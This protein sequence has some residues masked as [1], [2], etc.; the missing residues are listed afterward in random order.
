[1]GASSSAPPSADSDP[2]GGCVPH[3]CKGQRRTH[4][5]VEVQPPSSAGALQ[6]SLE[7]TI[8]QK[9]A[10]VVAGGMLSNGMNS[11]AQVFLDVEVG[12]IDAGKDAFAEEPTSGDKQG[13]DDDAWG[14]KTQQDHVANGGSLEKAEDFAEK[15]LVVVRSF[16]H[17][18]HCTVT[19][20]C[21]VIAAG[22]VASSVIGIGGGFGANFKP[23]QYVHAIY[24]IFFAGLIVLLDGEKS[25]FGRLGKYQLLLFHWLPCL[26]TMRGRALLHVYVGS[27]NLAMMSNASNFFWWVVYLSLGGCLCFAGVLL[28]AHH[29]ASACCR[30]RKQRAVERAHAMAKEA[31]GASKEI[32]NQ[33]HGA[34]AW[35]QAEVLEIRVFVRSNHFTVKLF[36]FFIAL[37]LMFFSIL[38]FFNLFHALF[39]PFQYLLGVYNIMF[40]F[41]MLILDGQASWCEKCGDPRKK[42]FRAAPIL[43]SEVGR[44][45][46]HFYVGSINIVMMP[47]S[48]FWQIVYGSL[49]GSLCLASFLM[50]SHYNWCAKTPLDLISAE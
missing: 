48:I 3:C 47:D 5:F 33:V 10:G 44:A 35:G 30:R 24:N 45:A 27:L 19:L 40:A 31:G 13:E 34:V 16:I 15:G 11:V 32:S 26:S 28:V 12:A 37:G 18:S 50:V 46:F 1:M 42:I 14:S 23:L 6:E 38:G 8:G 25:M 4:E 29:H 39:N 49:G 9:M 17:K 7:S 43:A 20:M 36:C 2:N 22:L 41:V 21:L